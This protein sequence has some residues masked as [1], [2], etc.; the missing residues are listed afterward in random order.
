MAHITI[1]EGGWTIPQQ[2]GGPMTLVAALPGDGF[3]LLASDS[4]ITETGGIK[5][6]RPKLDQREDAPIAWGFAGDEGLALVFGQWLKDLPASDLENPAALNGRVRGQGRNAER[7]SA[8]KSWSLAHWRESPS[9]LRDEQTRW[10]G[11]YQ[12]RPLRSTSSGKAHVK[13]A[14]ATLAHDRSRRVIL[15]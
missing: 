12:Q 11:D 7:P 9:S 13:I 1:P 2:N 6:T 4:Q 15:W 3:I 14:F 5:H 8:R 10:R